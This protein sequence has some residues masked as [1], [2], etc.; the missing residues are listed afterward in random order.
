MKRRLTAG[1]LILLALTVPAA[2]I[3]QAEDEDEEVREARIVGDKLVLIAGDVELSPDG[4]FAHET[5][6]QSLVFRRGEALSVDGVAG[7]SGNVDRIAVAGGRLVIYLEEGR[8]R[9]K[10]APRLI[11]EDGVWRNDKTGAELLIDDGK[12]IKCRGLDKS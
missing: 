8:V 3:A 4:T 7:M 11:P 12:V 1:L 10:T 9:N 2:A 6:G 5:G